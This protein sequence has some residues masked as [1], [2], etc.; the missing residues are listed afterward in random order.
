MMF[1][2]PGSGKSFVAEWLTSRFSAVRIRADDLRIAM[3]DG[4]RPEL[5]TPQNKALVNNA[6][7]YTYGQILRADKSSVVLDAN[8]NQRATRRT[9]EDP[10]YRYGAIP[11]V[12]WVKTPIPVAKERIQ[13]RVET[14]GQVIFDPRII[15][16]MLKRMQPPKDDE[17]VIVLSGLHSTK[18][19][20]A[21]FE[22]QFGRLKA[23]Q[24]Q[25]AVQ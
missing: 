23:E 15:E 1:G 8:Y 19:Q 6:I 24:G 16:K 17:N 20:K 12:V 9:F 13:S 22:E 10:A 3:F 4:D 18:E 14:T 5:Y 11:I 2:Y 25:T 7:R 21:S